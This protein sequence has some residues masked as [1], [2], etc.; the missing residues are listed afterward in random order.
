MPDEARVGAVARELTSWFRSVASLV[1]PALFPGD[2]R[3]REAHA[4]HLL[5]RSAAKLVDSRL[6]E[7]GSLYTPLCLFLAA[8]CEKL[9]AELHPEL[10]RAALANVL[11]FG[12]HAE[13]FGRILGEGSGEAEEPGNPVARFRS[14]SSLFKRE[15]DS[16]L[17]LA[18]LTTQESPLDET[19]RRLALEMA[20]NWAVR[21]LIAYAL[22]ARSKEHGT[23]QDLSWVRGQVVPLLSP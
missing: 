6:D 9:R 7:T 19:N 18:G 1:Q 22:I 16:S 13:L 14:V 12:E 5:L 2:A 10:W 21:L 4:W 15:L 20:V 23:A 3:E 11:S 8:A 17:V